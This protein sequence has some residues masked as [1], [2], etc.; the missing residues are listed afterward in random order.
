MFFHLHR[1]L[2]YSFESG[3]KDW[4]AVIFYTLICIIM[5][6]VLQEYVIDVSSS[7]HH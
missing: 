2:Q 3:W 7:L 5:H 1:G 4:C 6:A